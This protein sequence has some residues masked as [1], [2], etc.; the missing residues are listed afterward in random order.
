[1]PLFR[2][3]RSL[4][5]V[6]LLWTCVNAIPAAA[7]SDAPR[8]IVKL[9]ASA[10]KVVMEP[11]ERFAT[12]GAGASAELD[13]IR[14]MALG[15]HV[16]ALPG[17]AVVDADAVAA[18]I[19]RLPEVEYAVPSRR[20][21]AQRWAN[22]TYF[23]EQ[24]Y[25]TGASSAIDATGAWD[26][27]TG[28]ATTIVAVVDSG[29]RPHEDL[30]GRLLPGYDFITAVAAS[31][32]GDGRDAD[33]SDPGDWFSPA[34]WADPY[35]P[36]GECS[37]EWSS[38]HGTA[39]AGV[40]A[41]NGDN[42]KWMAGVDWNARILPVR[43]L[44]KCGGD[45]ADIIDALAWAGGLSVPGVP[46]NAYPAHVI[47]ISLSGEGLCPE[48]YSDVIQAIFSHGVTRAVVGAAGNDGS[49]R[50]QTPSGCEGVISV[51]ATTYAGNRAMYSSFGLRTDIAAPGGDGGSSPHN[52]LT[53]DNTG[54][55]TP[56][57]DAIAYHA[58]TSF[59]APLVSGTAALMLAVAPALTATQIRD[60]LK[61][62]ARA[63]SPTATCAPGTCG[64]G[65][66][67]AASAVR[68]AQALAG[69]VTFVDV[70]EYYS[71]SRDHYFMTWVDSEIARL[72]SG[73]TVGWLRTG[74]SFRAF[75]SVRGGSRAVCR[76][77]IPP[78]A[79]DGHFYGRDLPECDGTTMRNPTFVLEAAAFFYLFPVTADACGEGRIPV[80]RLFSNRSDANHRYTT[81][82]RVRD[83][84]VAQ[85]WL[86]EGDGP[87]AVAM[88]APQ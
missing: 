40:I 36:P 24:F 25:L 81:D 60:A 86:A 84:M 31:N 32:D 57:A 82:A 30:T 48:P 34:D 75:S 87:D 55:T 79:G 38:W 76:I 63:F 53:L 50:A 47:N 46:H 6:V 12:V 71:A 13:Y 19:A 78:G 11:R 28:A 59:A 49:Q 1:M 54:T 4:P 27:T 5:G 16:V 15:A 73:A 35:F 42:G 72:D 74:Q 58:G 51:A 67:D 66:L 56:A 65:L 23:P 29:F 10:A 3:A 21:K 26:I 18:R 80:Y 85:G 88:C 8:L 77:Y 9:R 68:A 83:Q 14:P 41:A 2:V 45:D 61:E 62:T 64:V 52:F 22:D 39:V 20:R 70:V 7:T 69:P 33:A 43:V 17:V 37:L 44:G